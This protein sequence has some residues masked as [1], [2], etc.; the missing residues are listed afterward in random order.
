MLS[1]QG[2]SH[3]PRVFRRR[4]KSTNGFRNRNA[5]L[6]AHA[7]APIR[8]AFRDLRPLAVS[9]FEPGSEDPQLFNCLLFRYHYLGHRNTS[10]ENIRYLVR[11]RAGRPAGKC[12]ARDA[13]I[14][15]D[16]ATREANL[17]LPTNNTRFLVLPWVAVP[18]LHG[19]SRPVRT[20]DR[21]AVRRGLIRWV[22]ARL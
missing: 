8:C 7:T 6:V 21:G 9:I 12:A 15:W 10:G 18:H 17:G 4:R 5:R 22:L 19:K 1:E 3:P 2:K 20:A 16:R 11:D 13:W 14:G